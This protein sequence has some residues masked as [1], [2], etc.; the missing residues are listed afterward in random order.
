LIFYFFGCYFLAVRHL[1][2]DRLDWYYKIGDSKDGPV[3]D[4]Q[5]LELA[6]LGK[7][8][9]ETMVWNERDARWQPFGEASDKTMEDDL[10]K[11]SPVEEDLTPEIQWDANTDLRS[12]FAEPHDDSAYIEAAPVSE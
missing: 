4:R 5:I 9:R 10:N 3:D 8:T 6:K 2:E 1:R 12:D 11:Q 7:I